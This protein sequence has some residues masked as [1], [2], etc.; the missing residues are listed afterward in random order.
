MI[1]PRDEVRFVRNCRVQ[2][3]RVQPCFIDFHQ[4]NSARGGEVMYEAI[5]LLIEP[6]FKNA[7]LRFKL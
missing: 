1:L 7:I 5:L 2:D 6:V 3:V 4:V